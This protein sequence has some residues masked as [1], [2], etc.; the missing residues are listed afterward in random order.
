M[1]WLQPLV[2]THWHRH[3]VLN[4]LKLI[5]SPGSSFSTH[6]QT[7]KLF[8]YYCMCICLLHKCKRILD[9]L[10]LYSVQC[11]HIYSRI[12]NII[13]AHPAI[14]VHTMWYTY[15]YIS[16]VYVCQFSKEHNHIVEWINENQ[17]KLFSEWC[18]FH[19]ENISCIEFWCVLNIQYIYMN[20]RA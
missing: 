18:H 3:H 10:W 1:T 6:S 5:S 13:H 14:D 11:I 19:Y 4:Q 2:V 20:V 8:D 9:E 12:Y 15:L 7:A 16:C 17:A